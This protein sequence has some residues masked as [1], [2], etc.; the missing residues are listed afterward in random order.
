MVEK[1]FI[2]LMP[3][4]SLYEPTGAH[5]LLRGTAIMLVTHDVKVVARTERVMF[6]CDGKIVSEMKIQKFNGTDI[7]G[8]V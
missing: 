8:R 2:S 5:N 6:M 7:D 3:S 4:A 1:F